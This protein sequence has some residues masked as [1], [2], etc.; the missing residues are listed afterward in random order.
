MTFIK[1]PCPTTSLTCLPN[2]LEKCYAQ[3]SSPPPI[4]HCAMAHFCLYRDV[5]GQGLVE[6]LVQGNDW[7]MWNGKS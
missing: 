7:N 2:W 1:E 6:A 5:Y 3:K 4:V